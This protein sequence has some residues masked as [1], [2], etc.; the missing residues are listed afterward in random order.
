M[1]LV[2][3]IIPTFNRE[4]LITETLDSVKDQM[5]EHWEC[6]VVDDGS[7]DNSEKVVRDYIEQDNRFQ[8]LKRPEN[9][10]KGAN[11]CRNIG[12]ENSSG[13]YVLWFDDDDLMLPHKIQTHLDL[14]N[15]DPDADG[16]VGMSYFFSNKTKEP[17]RPWRKKLYSDNLTHDFVRREVGWSIGDCLWKRSSLEGVAFNE[18]LS[19]SQ[20]WEFNLKC[21]IRGMKFN[22]IE[23]RLSHIRG[24][25]NSIKNT[26]SRKN[27]Y[28]D[29]L[30][31]KVIGNMLLANK[32]KHGLTL[33]YLTSEFYDYLDGF[34]FH[35][36]Y[37]RSVDCAKTIMKVGGS[38][39]NFFKLLG[40]FIF[41]Y[42][43]KIIKKQFR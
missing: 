13:E 24:T 14:F 26:R 41:I 17:L 19:S 11:A 28:S 33:V 35:A 7:T 39:V 31:R 23:E 32:K 5:Y 34:S 18:E 21:L 36:E 37:T 30:A 22:F 25:F 12:F 1:Q 16:S 43:L 9:R 10:S 15:D 2:S 20:D 38:T 4:T 6:L 29:Y 27:V 3:I 8:Y 42:P 40:R